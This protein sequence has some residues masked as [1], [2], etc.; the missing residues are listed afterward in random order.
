[1]TN[2][3]RQG[4]Q[5]ATSG[6]PPVPVINI[7]GRNI[8]LN[9]LLKVH[10]EQALPMSCSIRVSPFWSDGNPASDRDLNLVL[11]DCYGLTSS[12]LWMKLGLNGLIDP[13]SLP[14]ALFN[15]CDAPDMKFEKLAI[16]KQVRGVFYNTEPVHLLP[17]GIA[18]I[19]GGEIWFSRKTTSSLLI[20][21]Q[22]YKTHTE[23]AQ[24]ML[25]LREKEIL[26][27]IAAGAPNGDIAEELCISLHTV[28]SH[29][30]SIYKKIEVRNRLEATLWV[31]RYL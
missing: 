11:F 19:L 6:G 25:T 13:A 20:E 27:A 9:N 14:V 30:Y 17:K 16:E 7:V 21:H 23:A 24:A 12:D 29:I 5:K 18:K 15:I 26:I 4:T 3:C 10:M 22:R 31:A 28:K 2:T 8:L 1:M